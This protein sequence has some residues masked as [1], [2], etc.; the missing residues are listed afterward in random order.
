MEEPFKA[1][2]DDIAASDAIAKGAVT[3]PK[4]HILVVEDDEDLSVLVSSV[5]RKEF[6][7]TVEPSGSMALATAQAKKPDVIL[8]DLH[9]PNVD[10]FEVLVQIKS[11]PVTATIPVICTSA[12]TTTESRNRTAQLGAIG[13]IKKP[14]NT[15]ELAK[16]I[17]QFLQAINVTLE[18]KDRDRVFVIGFNEAEKYRLIR[19]AIEEELAKDHPVLMLSWQMGGDFFGMGDLLPIEKERLIYL[20]IKPALVTKF[21]YMQDLSPIFYDIKS[22]L[23]LGAEEYTLIFDEPVMLLN[24]QDNEV[25]AGKTFS[26]NEQLRKWFL[27]CRFYS[28][29]TRDVQQET[30]LNRVAKV[31]VGTV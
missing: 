11:H 24:S 10:G 25:A 21:P 19:L 4:L 8:L 2:F 12:D 16:D 30:L 31:F 9:M 22:F 26:L 15:K 29:K 5:L 17:K 3:E 7:V 23:L 18:S 27:R 6:K 13:F 1:V 14:P 28:T 20:Q